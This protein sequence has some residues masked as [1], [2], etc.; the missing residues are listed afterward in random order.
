MSQIHK[1]PL[2]VQQAICQ[3]LGEKLSYQATIVQGYAYE[4]LELPII[5]ASVTSQES[6]QSGRG[7]TGNKM[8][9]V[10]ITL[11]TSYDDDIS[12]HWDK[13]SEIEDLFSCVKVDVLSALNEC[14][15]DIGFNNMEIG[16][17]IN[18]IDDGVRATTISIDFLT[19]IKEA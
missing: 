1:T 7:S 16:S 10:L 17:L 9:T 8:P 6:L 11:Q 14:S 18:V 19:Y 2:Y 12:I 15:R 4:E 3:L 13:W 5:S